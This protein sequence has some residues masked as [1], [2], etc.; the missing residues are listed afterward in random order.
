MNRMALRIALAAMLG[1]G[2]MSVAV[3]MQSQG[4]TADLSQLP[5]TEMRASPDTSNVLVIFLTGDGGWAS[6]DKQVT[7]EIRAHGVDVIGLNTRPYLG[8]KKTPAEI[9][10]DLTRIARHYMTAWNRSRLAIVGYSRGADLMPFGV[11]GMPAD[12]RDKT[13]LLAFLGLATRAGFEFHFA[14]IMF[15]VKR[16]SDQP[17]L[18]TL[19]QLK[20]MKML[21]IYGAEEDNSACRAAPPGLITRTVQLPGGHHYDSDYKR[22]G[23][24]VLEELRSAGTSR[25]P[26]QH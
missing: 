15:N 11:T 18:P 12:L 4:A 9:A 5:L 6:I 13:V 25:L 7:A 2:A 20:G 24:L 16:D 17:T 14:D 23:D 8:R 21:C 10:F 26:A 19:A 1:F 22:V 3:G